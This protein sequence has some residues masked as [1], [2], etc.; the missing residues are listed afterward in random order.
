[1]VTLTYQTLS[2]K[3]DWLNLIDTPLKSMNMYTECGFSQIVDLATRGPNTLDL[4]SLL[5]HH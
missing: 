5:I 1:M 2:G 4:Y 3:I